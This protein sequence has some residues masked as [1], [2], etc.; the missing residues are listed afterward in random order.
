VAAN[1]ERIEI[2]DASTL[3]I[4]GLA[5]QVA[6]IILKQARTAGGQFEWRP[7][8]RAHYSRPNLFRGNASYTGRTRGIDYTLSLEDQTGRGGLGGPELFHAA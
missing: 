8:F 5:G 7:D 6:N 4:A 1:V 3:G 2:V